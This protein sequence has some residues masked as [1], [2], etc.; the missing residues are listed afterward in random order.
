MKVLLLMIPFCM[1]SIFISHMVQ[2]KGT[3]KELHVQ[4]KN[5][6]IS[7]MVQMKV[8]SYDMTIIKEG[9][10]YIPHGSDE[11]VSAESRP[12]AQKTFISHMVQMKVGQPMPMFS[13]AIA[14]YPTWFRWKEIEVV[15]ATKPR[16][17][18]YPTWFRWKG[19]MKWTDIQLTPAFISHMVQMK[20]W[21]KL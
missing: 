2:M 20:V 4:T 11:S 17:A 3:R 19:N 9:E 6:F 10:L 8:P 18:L 15:G 16:D 13:A 1:N 21:L 7:H 5:A 14:L 12:R